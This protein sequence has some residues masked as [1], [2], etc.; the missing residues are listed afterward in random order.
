MSDSNAATTEQVEKREALVVDLDALDLQTAPE[1][2]NVDTNL[3][4][5]SSPPPP[6]DGIHRFKLFVGKEWKKAET[7][8]TNTVYLSNQLTAKCVA[9]GESFNNMCGFDFVNTLVFEGK[10]RMGAIIKFAGGE[11]PSSITFDA[12]AKLYRDT[13]APEPIVKIRG[14][15]KAQEKNP[16][17]GKYVTVCAGMRNFPPLKDAEGKIIPG[18]FNHVVMGPK[19]KEMVS[20]KFEI[21]EYYFD[22]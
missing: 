20:A 4:A 12:L 6:P 5:F 16:E 10:S 17:D 19:S 7:Q 13:L 1:E 21:Q 2:V 3:D 9:E 15:W 14:R 22:N 8:K 11:V 18:K